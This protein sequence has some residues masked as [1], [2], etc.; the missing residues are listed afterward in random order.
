MGK[1]QCDIVHSWRLTEDADEG[2]RGY[3]GWNTAIIPEVLLES[4]SPPLPPPPKSFSSPC[5]LT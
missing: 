3:T 1:G 2:G 4:V 5:F